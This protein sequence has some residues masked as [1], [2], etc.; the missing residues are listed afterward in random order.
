[1]RVFYALANF[2]FTTSETQVNSEDNHG[3][4]IMRNFYILPIFPFSKSEKKSEY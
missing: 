1:M 3:L 4:N 2:I